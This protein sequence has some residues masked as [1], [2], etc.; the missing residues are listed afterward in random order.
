MDRYGY[1]DWNGQLGIDV[2]QNIDDAE[3]RRIWDQYDIIIRKNP[4][5]AYTLTSTGHEIK[6]LG[7]DIEEINIRLQYELESWL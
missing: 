6:L 2:R 4:A 3:L 5:G 7:V 1:T